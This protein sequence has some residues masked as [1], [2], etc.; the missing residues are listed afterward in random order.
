[1]LEFLW[2]T[3]EEGIKRPKEACVLKWVYYVDYVDRRS[4]AAPCSTVVPR[5]HTTHQGHRDLDSEKVPA[6][7]KIFSDISPL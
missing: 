3:V 1:M 5:G 4:T 2:E 6:S 7:H